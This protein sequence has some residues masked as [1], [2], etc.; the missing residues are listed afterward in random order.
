MGYYDLITVH[1][2]YLHKSEHLNFADIVFISYS[3]GNNIWGLL[4]N[5]G[6]ELFSEPVYYNLDNVPSDIAVGD[7]DQDGSED[8]LVPNGSN[9]DAWLN[10]P[11]GLEYYNFSV[12]DNS[13]DIK[14]V[15]IDND[16]DNDLV[17]TYWGAPG[18]NKQIYIY[19]NN[20]DMDFEL[21][22]TKTISE[23]LA[24]IYI[25]DLNNDHLPDII[26]NC[27][28]HFPNSANEIFNTY[29]LF[30]NIDGSFQDPV[31]YYTGICSHK[32]HAAD[33]DGNGW[34]DIITLNYDFYN[35][36]PDTCTIHILHNDGTG[37]FVEEAQVGVNEN[38]IL[39]I[40]DFGLSNYPNPFNPETTISF[41]IPKDSNIDLTVYNIKG[42]KVKTLF[43]DSLD[44]GDYSVVWDG[45]D[46]T[47]RAVSSGIYF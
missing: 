24:E 10:L 14:I 37:N 5:E 47:D 16:N 20:G 6:G 32:S 19:T 46:D 7:L 40:D 36:P 45:N 4:H 29:I 34:N 3:N 8:I 35:P 21:S 30:Q 28:I 22:Y 31:S 11:A 12:N 18:S 43:N 27:S 44:K 2:F 1:N 17:G 13:H 25:S 26:Y 33:L 41:S 23:G 38:V 39:N 15:D 42:Q 9:L